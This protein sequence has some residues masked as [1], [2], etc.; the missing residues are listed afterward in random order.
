MKNQ[1]RET[2]QNENVDVR[3]RTFFSVVLIVDKQKGFFFV[4]L[5]ENRFEFHPEIPS[6]LGRV[7]KAQWRLDC[8]LF[9]LFFNYVKHNLLS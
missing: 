5:I 9:M 8:D 1:N 7:W 6:S 2:N 3:D 4:P